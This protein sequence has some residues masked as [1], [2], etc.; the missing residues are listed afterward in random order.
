MNAPTDLIALKNRQQT[1]WASGDYAVIGTTLADRRRVSSPKPAT[2]APTSACSTSPPATAMRRWPPR[3]AAAWSTSTDYVAALLERGAERAARRAPAGRPSR[4]PTPRRCRSTTRASTPSLSTFGVMF[5]PDQAKAAAELA[6][7]VPPRR[8]DRSGQLDAGGLHRPDVQDARPARAA[9]GR[10]C[11]RRR[12]GLASRTCATLFDDAPQPR[13]RAAHVQLPLSLGGA[14][15][16]C[17]PDLVR[18]GAQGLRRAAGRARRRARTRP[19]RAARSA[20]S[21]WPGVAGRAERVPGGR[22]D[23]GADVQVRM[24]R[25]VQRYGWDLAAPDYE[26]LW[27]AQLGPAQA[28]MLARVCLRAGERVVDVACGTGLVSFAA[29][30]VVGAARPSDRRRHFRRDGR[31]GAAPCRCSRCRPCRVR[32]DGR[33]GARPRRRRL[34]RRALR[35]RPDVRADPERALRE[36]RRVVRPGGRVGLAVWGE[37]SRCDWAAVFPIVD[38][39]VRSDV[40]PMF[41]SLGDGRCAGPSLRRRR[42]GE[43]RTAPHRDDARLRQTATKRA[44]PPSS[45][46]R[47]RSPGRASTPRR[48][49]ASAPGTSLRSRRVV[50]P[51]DAI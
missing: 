29:A 36:L 43:R 15:H 41:F 31:R 44:T 25:R 4:W 47:S 9:T 8:A 23:A 20:E 5:A 40:C 50:S 14:L 24:Q 49:R 2:C 12:L 34:R 39:E 27:Q 21:G 10:A 16:R 37:R 17:L 42:P 7:R 26:R 18:A 22:R 35:P 6:A 28:D 51:M 11:S 3:A 30:D 33:R 32:A 38:A 46:A 48:A 19:H 13:D 45:A 1:A